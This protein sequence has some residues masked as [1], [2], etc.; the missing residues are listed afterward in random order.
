MSFWTAANAAIA[1][2]LYGYIL[3]RLRGVPD[4][5]AFRF[6]VAGHLLIEAACWPLYHQLPPAQYRVAYYAAGLIESCLQLAVIIAVYSAMRGE[7]D[8]DRWAARLAKCAWAVAALSSGGLDWVEI[9]TLI[10]RA[11]TLAVG[12]CLWHV[13]VDGARP[14]RLRGGVLY[15]LALGAVLRADLYASRL[16]GSYADW[17]RLIE[18]ADLGPWVIAA[19]AVRAAGSPARPGTAESAARRLRARAA[20]LLGSKPPLR[21]RRQGRLF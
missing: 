11:Q 17:A 14:G 6:C 5:G 19:A 15:A 7:G 12:V 2:A 3:L 9:H 16:G 21:W 4:V 13:A 8:F 1:F 20:R 18:W 10:L